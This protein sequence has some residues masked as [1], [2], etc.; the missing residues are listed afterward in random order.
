MNKQQQKLLHYSYDLLA[1][2]RYTISEMIKKLDGK[3]QKITSPCTADE[4]AEILA[5]LIKSN[6]LNDKTFAEFFIDAQIRRRPTG[7][8][9]LKQQLKLKGVEPA[10]IM[11][12]INSAA[13]DETLLARHLLQKKLASMRITPADL[14]TPS[15]FDS[16]LDRHLHH[17]QQLKLKQKL[18]R[19]LLSHGFPA[20]TISK[21]LN[22]ASIMEDAE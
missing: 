15:S 14:E 3:N 5:S 6:F 22:T 17:T 4:L 20:T 18:Y 13:L 11:Q 7:I 16:Y 21:L 1:T 2:R 10:I 9:K 8:F 19:H 12:A